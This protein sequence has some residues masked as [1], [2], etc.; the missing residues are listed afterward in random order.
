MVQGSAF[1][2]DLD[3]TLLDSYKVIVDSLYETYREFGLELSKPEIHQHSI[4]YSVSSFLALM[5][6]K[7]GIPARDAQQRYSRISDGKK[8]EI[9]LMPHAKEI[10]QELSDRGA[11][12]FVYTHRGVTTMPVLEHLGIAGCFREILTSVSGFARKP[13]GEAVRYLMEKYSLDPERTF[14]VGDRSLDMECAKDA[15]ARGILFLDPNGVG[16]P[17]GAEDFV[18]H[19]LMEIAEIAEG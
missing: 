2:W 8:L 7:K 13:S 19:D 3:G 10:L 18:V 5:E 9:T 11:Q 12:N 15:F 4:R 16:E 17:T 14:Y 1:I 6:E